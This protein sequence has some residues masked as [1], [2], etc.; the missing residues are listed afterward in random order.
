M[1]LRDLDYH[2]QIN[3][4]LKTQTKILHYDTF[5]LPDGSYS[6]ADI[7]DHFDFIIKKR[8]TL[9][10]NPAVKIYPNK[11]KNRIVFK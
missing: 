8:E 10:E 1:R 2:Q 5:A 6:I 7:Q 3:L 11:I 9:T 4:I